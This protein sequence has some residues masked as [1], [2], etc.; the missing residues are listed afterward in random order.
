MKRIKFERVFGLVQIVPKVVTGVTGESRD[1]ARSP[2][3]QSRR[4][5][6]GQT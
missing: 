2:N 1:H 6:K 3:R 4:S 5:L